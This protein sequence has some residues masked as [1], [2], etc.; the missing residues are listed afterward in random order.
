MFA[1]DLFCHVFT[2]KTQINKKLCKII[3]DKIY[4]KPVFPTV[5]QVINTREKTIWIQQQKKNLL[6]FCSVKTVGVYI[7]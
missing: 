5:S 7:K 1:G 2:D 6:H 4:A 3:Y